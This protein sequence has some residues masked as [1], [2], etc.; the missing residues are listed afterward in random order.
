MSAASDQSALFAAFRTQND[1]KGINYASKGEHVSVHQLSNLLVR[2]VFRFR[3]ERWN[4][5]PSRRV[6]LSINAT[7][8]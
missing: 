1:A 8:R 3:D 2:E 6:P 4:C 7:A 5:L